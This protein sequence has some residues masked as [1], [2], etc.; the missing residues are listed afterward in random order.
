MLLGILRIEM[1][2]DFFRGVESRVGGWHATVNGSLQ[3]NF[4][5]FVA[6]YAERECGFEVHA[7]FRLAVLSDEHCQGKQAAGF[8]RQAGATPDFS[9]SVAGDQ[10]LKRFIE[11]AAIF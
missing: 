2:E 7:E 11:F 4:L 9:P 5:N 1:V 6:R 10:I 8:T 3:K